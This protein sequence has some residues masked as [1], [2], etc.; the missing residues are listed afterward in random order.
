M[1]SLFGVLIELADAH[2]REPEISEALQQTKQRR[3][4]RNPANK[5]GVPV[6]AD[7]RHA[8]E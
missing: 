8:L 3:L 4:I 1:R 5:H 6:I 7:Q 2:E